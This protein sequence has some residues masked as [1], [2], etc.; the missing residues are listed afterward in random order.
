MRASTSWY[1]CHGR[2][3]CWSSPHGCRWPQESSPSSSQGGCCARGRGEGACWCWVRNIPPW[4]EETRALPP[5]RRSV[6]RCRWCR[7]APSRPQA[8]W[9]GWGSRPRRWTPPRPCNR[10]RASRQSLARC[11]A[12]SCATSSKTGTPPAWGCPQSQLSFF[13]V[14]P[15]FQKPLAHKA[16]WRR[17][18]PMSL[19]LSQCSW[20]YLV[21]LCYTYIY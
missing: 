17:K 4:R 7:A 5:S 20:I 10:Q 16:P 19:S 9:R 3:R 15:S 1:V 6:G 13:E 12:A 14:E 8:R 21:C 2:S 18:S 11:L